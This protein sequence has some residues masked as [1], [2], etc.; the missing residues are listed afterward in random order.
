M[1]IALQLL[2]DQ[3]NIYDLLKAYQPYYFYAG[4]DCLDHQSMKYLSMPELADEAMPR[5]QAVL[6]VS[7]EEVVEAKR[8]MEQTSDTLVLICDALDRLLEVPADYTNTLANLVASP[9]GERSSDNALYDYLI[10][11]KRERDCDPDPTVGTAAMKPALRKF[12]RH[13]PQ[14][15]LSQVCQLCDAQFGNKRHLQIHWSLAHGGARRYHEVLAALEQHA[16]HVVTGTECRKC[17]EDS[18]WHHATGKTKELFE[19]FEPL[20]ASH[21]KTVLWAIRGHALAK[22]S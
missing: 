15:M 8:E 12:A 16:P 21:Q 10:S 22:K 9:N 6:G 17:V 20:D 7:N 11:A 3:L 5:L 13:K 4:A 19:A 1:L 18:V 2:P 14:P